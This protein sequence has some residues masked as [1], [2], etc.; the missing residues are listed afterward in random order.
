MMDRPH[1]HISPSSLIPQWVPKV[2]Q[3]LKVKRP[4]L[5]FIVP[6]ADAHRGLDRRA[7]DRHLL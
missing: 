4:R 2:H 1:P 7:S 3:G 6:K 5:V